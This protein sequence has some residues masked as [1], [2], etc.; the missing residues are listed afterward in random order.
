MPL[1]ALLAACG[2]VT[3]SDLVGP[4]GG[5]HALLQLTAT[6]GKIEY[7]CAHG[8]ISPGWTVSESGM[9]SATG[10][11]TQEHGG[12]IQVGEDVIPRPARY[13]AVID[14]DRMALTVTL[15]DSAQ[16]LGPFQL[17][18]GRNGSVFKCV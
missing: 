8:T 18:H 16:V 5:D 15:T 3:P 2:T 12:P 13:S 9:F 10:T 7:D 1:L 4:W 14:G 6:T 17:R 11:H